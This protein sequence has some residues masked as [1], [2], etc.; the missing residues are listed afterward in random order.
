MKE[1]VKSVEGRYSIILPDYLYWIKKGAK[2]HTAVETIELLQLKFGEHAISKS[3]PINRPI[4][5]KSFEKSG[6]HS[7]QRFR[8]GKFK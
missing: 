5:G 4:Y 3:E 1:T 7:C 8:G 6:I 2:Y